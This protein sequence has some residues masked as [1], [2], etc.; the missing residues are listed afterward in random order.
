MER[1]GKHIKCSAYA[2]YSCLIIHVV[3]VGHKNF[4]FVRVT[5]EN[6][7][8]DLL[9]HVVSSVETAYCSFYKV[10]SHYYI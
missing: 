3:F 6:L 2:P 10:M 7:V 9:V 5:S 1:F 4:E 8:I